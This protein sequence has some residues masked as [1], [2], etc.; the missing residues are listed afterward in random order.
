MKPFGAAVF[1]ASLLLV[2]CGGESPGGSGASSPASPASRQALETAF[3]PASLERLDAA[4]A[5]PVSRG[6]VPNLSYG[7]LHEGE[8]VLQGFH[9]TRTQGG[10]EPV[11]EDTL[12][13]IYSM[14]K[15]ITGVAMLMLYED[16]LWSPDDPVTDH[17]PELADLQ[18][19]QSDGTLAPAS[20]PP[21]V[22]ELLN[23]TAGFTYGNRGDA[24]NRAFLEARVL[25]SSS[26]DVMAE[27]LAD[28][29]LLFEPGE[30]WSYSVATDL[31]GLIIERLSGQTLGAFFEERIFA[32][33]GM[34]STGF[35]VEAA[36]QSRLSDLVNPGAG[37]AAAS[38][39]S[40]PAMT[41]ARQ[42][43]GLEAGGSGLVSTLSDYQKFIT[44]LAGSGTLD[45]VR[46][47]Q[48]ETVQ[49]M[50][51]DRVGDAPRNARNRAY[52]MKA[53]RGYGVNVGVVTN[54]RRLGWDAPTGTWHWYGAAGT[55]FWHDPVN[56]IT[57]IGMIQS[58]PPPEGNLME[59]A[60]D[61][62]YDAYKR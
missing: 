36:D 18:V 24:A 26:L 20:R 59:D 33:L 40:S 49:M 19:L 35:Y 4:M 54:A 23:H 51:T 37:G 3:T 46:L 57:F 15:P 29:P 14:T 43:V 25:G 2:A 13:R 48:P 56:N 44:M 5:R 47:L 60:M 61:A 52:R 28:V 6:D 31:Q 7:L 38:V 1:A 16:G 11:N 55:W 12:Y 10:T 9:G 27:K 39:N 41:Y 50:V 21:T 8:I 45:G 34:D 53:G 17:I 42:H 58:S 32:P 30:G 22:G 62:V